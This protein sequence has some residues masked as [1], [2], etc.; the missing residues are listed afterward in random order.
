MGKVYYSNEVVRINYNISSEELFYI[1]W[2][3]NP[4]P[5]GALVH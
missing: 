3:T 4:S 5:Y 2:V 1:W